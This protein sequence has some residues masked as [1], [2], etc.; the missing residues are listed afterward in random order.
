MYLYSKKA[1]WFS[2]DS[3]DLC[4]IL[5][6]SQVIVHKTIRSDPRKVMSVATKVAIQLNCKLGGE[7]W[8]TDIPVSMVKMAPHHEK[9]VFQVSD[10]VRHKP[11]CTTTQIGLKFRI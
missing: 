3:D 10:Q 5:V 11:G 8:T 7:V 1:I 2:R 4:V 6:P 9:T